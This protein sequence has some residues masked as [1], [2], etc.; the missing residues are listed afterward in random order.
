MSRLSRHLQYLDSQNKSAL[1]VEEREAVNTP[2][3]PLRS[4]SFTAQT[5]S[6]GWLGLLQRALTLFKWPQAGLAFGLVLAAVLVF[7][8]S[9]SWLFPPAVLLEKS[10]GMTTEI[11]FEVFDSS[12]RPVPREEWAQ[13]DWSHGKQLVGLRAWPKGDGYLALALFDGDDMFYP[14][15]TGGSAEAFDWFALRQKEPFVLPRVIEVS[16]L[17]SEL[18]AIAVLCPSPSNVENLSEPELRSLFLQRLQAGEKRAFVGNCL[19]HRVRLAQ[20]VSKSRAQ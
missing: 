4:Q 3:P 14:S 8:L 1:S 16:G 13:L 9:R 11:I 19:F 2:V 18:L 20:A 6:W 17:E 15:Q 5:E 10:S 12:H 7:P